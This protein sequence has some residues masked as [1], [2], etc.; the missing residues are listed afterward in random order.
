M[1][2]DEQPLVKVEL[3]PKIPMITGKRLIRY[4]EWIED[5][6]PYVSSVDHH[7]IKKMENMFMEGENV[8][9][10]ARLFGARVNV[11]IY[12]AEKNEWYDKL[13]EKMTETVS[14]KD[15]KISLYQNQTPDFYASLGS[16]LRKN[17]QHTIDQYSRTGDPRIL[18]TMN[19]SLIDKIVK[20]D[21]FLKD[22]LDPKNPASAT[23]INIINNNTA[24]ESDDTSE[25]DVTPKPNDMSSSTG[26]VL[27]A[28]ADLKRRQAEQKKK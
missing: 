25:I 22:S 13:M 9:R 14:S 15:F 6:M 7:D 17:V 20:V 19:V 1:S 12:H 2:A 24:Q 3:R 8:Y 11:V 21:T 28:I 27:K 10:I 5:G 16:F 4:V 23:Q 26:D 18:D